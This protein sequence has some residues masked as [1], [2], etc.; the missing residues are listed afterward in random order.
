MNSP[1]QSL[2]ETNIAQEI[3]P[4]GIYLNQVC[5]K[6]Q[7]CSTEYIT[8]ESLLQQRLHIVNSN[9]VARMRKRFVSQVIQAVNERNVNL[10]CITYSETEAL[11]QTATER[12]L[13]FH[14]YQLNGNFYGN[15][16]LMICYKGTKTYMLKVL[17]EKEYD[18]GNSF[19][20]AIASE[21]NDHVIDFEIKCVN[22]KFFMFMPCCVST[23][24]SLTKLCQ[25]DSNKLWLQIVNGLEFMHSKG[26]AHMDV[27]SP[28][29]G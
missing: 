27:K 2:I 6:Q 22:S 10:A 1:G 25:E 14:G 15:A 4:K 17:T 5:I 23:L 21:S 13:N 3:V 7:F 9:I 8:L 12:Q 18:R 16:A 24:E 26:F 28:N 20:Q 29:I 19:L 11:P